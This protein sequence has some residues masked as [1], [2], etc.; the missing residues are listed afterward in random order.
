MER[1]E[2]RHTRLA[3]FAD[4]LIIHKVTGNFKAKT[5]KG[6]SMEKALAIIQFKLEEQTI[7]NYPVLTKWNHGS[8]WTGWLRCW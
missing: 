4:V 1:L 2:I 8:G 3:E 5:Q 7:R 6:R